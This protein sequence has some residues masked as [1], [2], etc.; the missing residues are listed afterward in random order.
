MSTTNGTGVRTGTPESAVAGVSLDRRGN[1]ATIRLD[2]PRRNALTPEFALGIRTA[3]ETAENDPEIGAVVIASAGKDYCSGADLSMLTEVAADPL[4]DVNFAAIGTIYGLFEHLRNSTLPTI[5]AV[6][7]AVVG[8]GMNLPL[9]CDLRIVSDD[10]RI[11]GFGKAGVHPGG[12]HLT[13]LTQ[14]LS[15]AA[16]AAVALFD[17]EMDAE[18][19]VAS[20]FAW[21]W[22]PVTELLDTAV[23][24]AQSVAGDP[25]LS[26][27]V[28]WTYRAVGESAPTPRAGVLLERAA[29]LWSMQRKLG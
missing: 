8:A 13:M 18:R 14:H 9:A 20:G 11:R 15:S 4:E 7:G 5:S 3:L 6:N 28:T 21:T 12:G 24:I 25:A 17:Q 29:Q 16:A 10:V 27:S 19:A 2:A 22:V 1:V 23:R 26:R